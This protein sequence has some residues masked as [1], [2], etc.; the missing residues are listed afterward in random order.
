[1]IGF[2][3][4]LMREESIGFGFCRLVSFLQV[5]VYAKMSCDSDIFFL[6]LLNFICM[7]KF[8]EKLLVWFLGFSVVWY[9]RRAMK[10]T[11][12][13]FYGRLIQLVRRNFILSLAFGLGLVQTLCYLMCVVG[14]VPLG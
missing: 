9:S 5:M 8:Y 13:N 6:T 12:T 3:S 11:C 10:S 7:W 2:V 14:L 1:M 4:I